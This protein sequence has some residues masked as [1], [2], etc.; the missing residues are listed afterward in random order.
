[1]RS[2]LTLIIFGGFIGSYFLSPPSPLN[3]C[4]MTR[5]T[6][7]S[8]SP[9]GS[10]PSLAGPTSTDS[11][12][13]YVLVHVLARRRPRVHLPPE[14][15]VDLPG[16]RSA[17]RLRRLHFSLVCVVFP[18]KSHVREK[19]VFFGQ[20]GTQTLETIFECHAPFR[21]GRRVCKV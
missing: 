17:I 3:S 16:E 4:C 10:S 12:P 15:C 19:K 6:G 20:C 14:E 18:T 8:F 7:F 11:F 13:L 21:R 1:M 5:S 9:A 2:C